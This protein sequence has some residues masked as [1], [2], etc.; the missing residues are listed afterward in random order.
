MHL[1]RVVVIK[2]LLGK[3]PCS[4]SD[5]AG[6]WTRKLVGMNDLQGNL[7][8]ELCGI[9]SMFVF[10][11]RVHASSRFI[12]QINMR[13][14]WLRRTPDVAVCVVLAT[15]KTQHL[16]SDLRTSIQLCPTF[17]EIAVRNI[18]TMNLFQRLKKKRMRETSTCLQWM[19]EKYN[20]I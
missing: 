2:F 3:L 7:H 9:G 8:K 14:L 15:L 20:L 10:V 17:N 11:T 1:T 18:S 5:H 4:V 6:F 13:L 16:N 19:I 12:V